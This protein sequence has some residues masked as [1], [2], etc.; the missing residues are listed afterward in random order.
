[1][2]LDINKL[3][4]T[5]F[6][7]GSIKYAPGTIASLVAMFLFFFVPNIFFFQLICILFLIAVG[8]AFCDRHLSKINEKDPQY[9]VLDEVIGM[10]IALFMIPKVWSYYI[11]CF[12]IFRIFDILKPSIIFRSQEF[13]KSIGVIADDILAGLLTLIL[14]WGYLF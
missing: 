10:I 3:L 1:M 5:F 8:L 2:K 6:Y 9:I 12:L 13:D 14:V 7:I 11:I 4:L